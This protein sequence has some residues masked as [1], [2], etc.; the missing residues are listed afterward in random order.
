MRCMRRHPQTAVVQ[1]RGQ[2]ELGAAQ[3][4]QTA[5]IHR[6]CRRVAGRQ[7]RRRD[8]QPGR[9]R[10][11]D[12][13]ERGRATG[14]ASA[15]GGRGVG[16]ARDVAQPL[17]LALLRLGA[18]HSQPLP[19][20][21]RRPPL[22][23]LRQARRHEGRAVRRGQMT[24]PHVC[25]PPTVVLL[26]RGFIWRCWRRDDCALEPYPGSGGGGCGQG[27][28]RLHNQTLIRSRTQA[29]VSTVTY[30]SKQNRQ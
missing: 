14:G 8:R 18:R 10:A 26:G 4:L 15:R 23:R 7:R 24:R 22:H 29:H 30:M 25:R 12:C 16:L 9:R 3:P 2:A 19:P 6:P 17:R 21:T 20:L 27:T 1:R 28:L 13:R 5:P 11:G